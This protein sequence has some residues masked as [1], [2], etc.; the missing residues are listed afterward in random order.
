MTC[1]TGI[2]SE[3]LIEAF[4]GG[5]LLGSSGAQRAGD[6][7]AGSQRGPE[8]MDLDASSMD[9]DGSGNA[10][11]GLEAR[12]SK[13][14]AGRGAAGGAGEGHGRSN[15][16]AAEGPRWGPTSVGCLLYVMLPP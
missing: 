10:G 16:A 3:A 1:Q 2:S 14:A 7:A 12:H 15:A 4:R 6:A 9:L 13:A 11:Q 8:G 5:G